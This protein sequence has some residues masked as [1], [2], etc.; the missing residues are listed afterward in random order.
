MKASCIAGICH[1]AR[2]CRSERDHTPRQL[3]DETGYSTEHSVISQSDIEE[4]ISRDI[5]LVRDWLA[6]TE[7]KRCT[8]AWGIAKRGESDWLVFHIRND[9]GCDYEVA[10]ASPVPACALMIRLEMEDFRSR[11]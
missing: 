6:F 1:F 10:F 7:D 3:Y 11:K 9:G 2:L 8:P 4:F 5:S